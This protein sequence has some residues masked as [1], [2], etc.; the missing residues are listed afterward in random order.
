MRKY[1]LTTRCKKNI[2]KCSLMISILITMF[3]ILGF[4]NITT[5]QAMEMPMTN[6]VEFTQKIDSEATKIYTT[7]TEVNARVGAD[8]NSKKVGTIADGTSVTID[9]IE[10]GE[11]GYCKEFKVYVNIAYLKKV[12]INDII[13]ICTFPMDRDVPVYSKPNG[14]DKVTDLKL[15]RSYASIPV[16]YNDKY[17][18]IG[19]NR[20]V[21]RDDIDIQYYQVGYYDRFI[22]DNT[23]R[24]FVKTEPHTP[25]KKVSS[26]ELNEPSGLSAEQIENMVKGTGLQGIGS[27]VK[28]VEDMYGINAY[29]TL[30]VA[31]YESG[32]GRSYL[33]VNQNN[34][35]GLDPYNGG[36]CF[37]DKSECVRYFGKLI[38]K[39]YFGKGLITPESINRVYE[40]YNSN[41]SVNVR[42]IM[43]TYRNK[44]K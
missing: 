37:G 27:A 36:M 25:F 35:F 22:K 31:S 29:F 43:Q 19:D 39:Y 26:S 20:F 6:A 38:T 21:N 28:E 17:I 16:L 23:S 33:A 4:S 9:W 40:P 5:N 3:V 34:I 2:V 30:A 44:L 18:I 1:D 41:W 7:T 14:F 13:G 8:I 11:W 15:S 12:E 24:G 42:S 32:Y 10:N